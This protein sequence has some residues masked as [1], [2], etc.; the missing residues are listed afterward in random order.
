ML[1][2]TASDVAQSIINVGSDPCLAT[3]AQQLN[4]LH[5]LESSG[6]NGPTQ[7]SAG[8]GLCYAVTPLKFLVWARQN[9][10][11]FLAFAGSVVGGI[12]YVGYRVGKRIHGGK[13][14][15]G[16]QDA[17]HAGYLR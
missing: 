12:G 10:W 17:Y 15:A 6:D 2:S 14:M 8:I 4:D 1:R 7:A 3:V 16:F 11:V 13:D 9:P 5:L